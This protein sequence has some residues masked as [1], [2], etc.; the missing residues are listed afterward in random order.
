MYFSVW[1]SFAN[2]LAVLREF[3]SFQGH[4]LFLLRLKMVLCGYKNELWH[5]GEKKKNEFVV[6][7]P[8]SDFKN[9]SQ[10]IELRSNPFYCFQY[11]SQNKTDYRK[12]L[13]ISFFF[14]FSV[15]YCHLNTMLGK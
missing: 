15:L 12:Q 2:Y 9:F 4:C 10:M 7:Q 3:L 6:T 5:A 11:F 13:V 8:A 14:L 1:I